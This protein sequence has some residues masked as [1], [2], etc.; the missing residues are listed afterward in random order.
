[1]A[2]QTL[3]L[4]TLL[5]LAMDH[6]HADNSSQLGP[7]SSNNSFGNLSDRD[8]TTLSIEEV[9]SVRKFIQ[10]VPKLKSVRVFASFNDDLKKCEEGLIDG[11]TTLAITLE[12]LSMMSTTDPTK[13][14][15]TTAHSLRD[16]ENQIMNFNNFCHSA[17]SDEDDL[18]M[19]L[20]DKKLDNLYLL[21]NNLASRVPDP[22]N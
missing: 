1:M 9:R 19:Q 15:A 18:I 12:G 10:L 11:L 7:N 21:I 2:I 16:I 3:I 6:A 17:L 5:L 13:R 22:F 14:H 20:L 4:A 8:V